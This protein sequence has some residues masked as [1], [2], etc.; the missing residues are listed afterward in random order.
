MIGNMQTAIMVVRG[1]KY[2]IRVMLKVRVE[3]CSAI[4][5]PH[6]DRLDTLRRKKRTKAQ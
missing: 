1:R 2:R 3:A 6:Y 5:W 4:C